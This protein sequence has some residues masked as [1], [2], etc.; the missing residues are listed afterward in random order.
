MVG[1]QRPLRPA[2]DRHGCR[3]LDARTAQ[4][5]QQQG[6]GL[7]VGVMRQRDEVARLPGKRRMAQLARRRFDTVRAQRG[8][9]YMFDMQRNGVARTESDTEIRPRIGVGA[10][11]MMDMQGG[12]LPGITRRELLQQVQQH[13]GINPAAQADQDGA[14]RGEQRRNLRRD[15]FGEMMVKIH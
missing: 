12:K 8:N 10:D 11:A 5:L 14:V 15:T 1:K 6:L 2:Q 3:P 13:N 9:V 7:V 4:Q